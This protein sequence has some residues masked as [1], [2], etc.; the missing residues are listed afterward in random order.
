MQDFGYQQYFAFCFWSAPVSCEGLRAP[1]FRAF[2]GVDPSLG[3][4]VWFRV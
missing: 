3:F 4:R 2:L 1:G